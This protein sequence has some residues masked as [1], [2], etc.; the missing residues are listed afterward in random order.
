MCTRQG[1]LERA[2]KLL[3]RAL[4]YSREQGFEIPSPRL[5]FEK[6]WVLFLYQEWA[7]SLICLLSASD[8]SPPTPFTQLLSAINACMVGQLDQAEVWFKDICSQGLEKNSVE[9]WIG[10]RASR[11]L[12]RRWFQLFPYELIYVTDF[13]NDMSPE[14]LDQVQHFL[15]EINMP[16][17]PNTDKLSHGHYRE[18]DE[19][20]VLLLLKGTIL[21]NL[22]MLKE[23][24]KLLEKVIKCQ[25]WILN[26]KW[27]VPHAHYEL[28]MVYLKGRDWKAGNQ[29]FT[30][31]KEFKKY[32]FRRSL[33][34]K[35]NSVLEFVYQEELKERK[36]SGNN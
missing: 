35:L 36:Y 26:E 4:S 1:K 31:A 24:V 21:R 34:F 20:A 13:L 5:L 11:Y 18:T 25:S 29:Q 3:K 27:L 9:K 7:Q 23:S 22:G 16:E 8:H 12:T 2:L 33:N 30:K 19:F 28:G 15:S 10:R 6:G 17:L 14:W 32:D